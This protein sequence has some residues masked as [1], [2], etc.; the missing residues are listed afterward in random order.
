MTYAEVQAI[1]GKTSV[2][3]SSTGSYL[4]EQSSAKGP[5]NPTPKRTKPPGERDRDGAMWIS[6]TQA[7]GDLPDGKY[8]YRDAEGRV[9]SVDRGRAACIE[10]VLLR[11]NNKSGKLEAAKQ[12]IRDE[13]AAQDKIFGKAA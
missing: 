13:F 1:I 5:F 8:R 9:V 10:S 11:R 3:G 6:E 4:G 2:S 7:R 12:K